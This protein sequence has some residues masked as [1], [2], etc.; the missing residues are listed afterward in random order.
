ML[1]IVHKSVVHLI[2]Y[3]AFTLAICLFNFFL[4][5]RLPFRLSR[6]PCSDSP[7]SMGRE[8]FQSLP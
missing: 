1:C 7:I 2:Q 5:I 3:V 8:H 4:L 6:Y